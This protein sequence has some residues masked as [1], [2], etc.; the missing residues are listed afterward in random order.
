MTQE[1]TVYQ[2]G[3]YPQDI[4]IIEGKEWWSV[5]DACRILGHKNSRKAIKSIPSVHVTK[6][7]GRSKDGYKRARLYVDEYG[8]NQL[9]SQSRTDQALAYKEW[10]FGT[11]LPTIRKTGS[12]S[13]APVV[14]QYDGGFIEALDRNTAMVGKV[15]DKVIS[16][17]S[18]VSAIESNQSWHQEMIVKTTTTVQSKSRERRTGPAATRAEIVDRVEYWAKGFLHESYDEAWRILYHNYKEIYGVDFRSIQRHRNLK[19]TIDAVQEEGLLDHFLEF[20]KEYINK[21]R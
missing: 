3:K 14:S 15:L 1:L 2:F 10:A 8:L 13:V 5:T 19:H 12:Y 20:V 21:W 4:Q 18:R 16:L 17:E 11:V 6:V 9:I 7:T